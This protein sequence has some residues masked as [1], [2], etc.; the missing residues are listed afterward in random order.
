M[1]KIGYGVLITRP[2]DDHQLHGA[3]NV[4][5]FSRTM[6]QRCTKYVRIANPSQAVS[7]I[8]AST[9][10]NSVSTENL[11][12]AYCFACFGKTLYGNNDSDPGSNIDPRHN[13]AAMTLYTDGH[14]GSLT[15]TLLETTTSATNDFFGHY[16]F[17]K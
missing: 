12:L 6:A 16:G 11:N 9:K 8:D 15:R 14:V 4:N 7:M 2:T 5:G 17:A 3:S 13:D 10:F 1:N